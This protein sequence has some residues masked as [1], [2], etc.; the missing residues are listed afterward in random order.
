[1]DGLSFVTE[2]GGLFALC[3]IAC[4]RNFLPTFVFLV[5]AR[6]APGMAHCPDALL[7]LAHQVPA[8]ML[9]D[10]ALLLFGA[11]AALEL[12]AN[13]NQTAREFLEEGAWDTYTKPFYAFVF[14]VVVGAPE[15]AAAVPALQAAVPDK[16]SLDA[17]AAVLARTNVAETVSQVASQAVETVASAATPAPAAAAPAQ[18]SSFFSWV[19]DFFASGLAAGGTWT[20]CQIRRQLA[21]AI[22]SLDPEN[23]F[24]LQTVAAFVEETT[25]AIL[26]LLVIVVPVLAVFAVC[27]VAAAGWLLRKVL[28]EMERRRSHPCPKCGQ[29]VH[30]SALKCPACHADQDPPCHVVGFMGLAGDATFDPAD[31][32]SR[33]T[34][35]L[36][37]LFAHRCPS[38]ASPLRGRDTCTRCDA[39]PWSHGVSREDLVQ[40]LDR[41]MTILTLVGMAATF[42]PVVG[43]VV[44]A[45]LVNVK[46]LAVLRAYE[47]RFGRMLSRI[48]FRL[49][50]W[51]ALILAAIFS[52][53]PFVGALLLLPYVFSYLASRR[54][55]L[56]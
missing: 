7:E 14:A 56:Q 15:A 47:D 32:T 30:N 50:K 13:W 41:R 36:A 40:I 38:C 22:R 42:V 21:D 35:D 25:W 28:A 10:G 31:A 27:S 18:G 17:V 34:H 54:K 4:M 51:T 49:L 24:K 46:V 23:S 37:L 3:G 2:I 6:M 9:T 53:V 52:T 16:E 39:S 20:L 45:V 48:C 5:L 12:F 19:G 29:P 11:M 55:F 1:M 44:A 33:R 8:A 26:L 43:F